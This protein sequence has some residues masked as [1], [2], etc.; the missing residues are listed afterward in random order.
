MSPTTSW[1]LMGGWLLLSIVIG[2][3]LGAFI[4]LGSSDE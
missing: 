4:K 1:L 2:L 3:L